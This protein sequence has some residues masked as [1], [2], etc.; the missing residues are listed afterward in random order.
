MHAITKEDLH[1]L[2]DGLPEANVD[3]A[4]RVLHGF[5]GLAVRATPD[6]LATRLEPGTSQ[7]DRLL[8]VVDGLAELEPERVR[9]VLN[10]LLDTIRGLQDRVTLL[11]TVD[12]TGALSIV[13][14]G[15]DEPAT[16]DAPTRRR[17]LIAENR[18]ALDLLRAYDEGEPGMA[19]RLRLP[20]RPRER[21]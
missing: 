7:A 17:R 6:S 9:R 14:P 11:A 15:G 13:E 12:T 8:L 10:Q 19:D 1:R 2:V 18:E 16:E 21:G 3:M 5:A 20:P 4:G